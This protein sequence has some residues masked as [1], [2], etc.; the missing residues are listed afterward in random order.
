MGHKGMAWKGKEGNEIEWKEMRKRESSRLEF[1][2]I[3]LEY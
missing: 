1:K 2:R 3:V